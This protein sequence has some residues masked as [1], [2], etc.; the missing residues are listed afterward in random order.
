YVYRLDNRFYK[1]MKCLDEYDDFTFTGRATRVWEVIQVRGFDHLQAVTGAKH[2]VLRDVWLDHGAAT[3]GETQKKIFER[4]EEVARNFPRDDDPRLIGVDN[5]TRKELRDRLAKG[6]YKKLFLTIEADHRGAKSKSVA[7]GFVVAPEIL[8][9]PEYINKSAT[10]RGA[11]AHRSNPSRSTLAHV[12]AGGQQNASTRE[13]NPKQRNFVVYEEVCRALHDILFMICWIHRDISSGNVLLHGGRGK[14]GDLEYAKEFDLSVQ[15]RSSDP[16][17]GTPIFM[18][19]EVQSECYIY[20]PEE[21]DAEGFATLP[22]SIEALVTVRHN[23][24]HDLESVFWIMLWVMIT[25]LEGERCNDAATRLFGRKET[26][27]ITGRQIN[28]CQGVYFAL[29]IQG[30]RSGLPSNFYAGLLSMRKELCNAY[31]QRKFNFG[32]MAS[33]SPVYGRLREALEHIAA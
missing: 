28:L 6:T 13:F 33:Y 10:K 17:T 30:L 3:E 20:D 7:E 27:F 21:D 29:S 19:V 18:A 11:D 16:K 25:R 26:H 9:H 12:V 1:T 23:F 32:D 5:A 4:C 15:K 22:D 8:E 14:L 2:A 24:Q 31:K